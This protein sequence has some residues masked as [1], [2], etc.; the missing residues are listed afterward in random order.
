MGGGGI[1]SAFHAYKDFTL[2]MLFLLPFPHFLHTGEEFT[3]GSCH[4]SVHYMVVFNMI[5]L[6]ENKNCI[7]KNGLFFN[8]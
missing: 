3:G 7:H 4:A 8:F 5:E 1:L 6:L 2:L